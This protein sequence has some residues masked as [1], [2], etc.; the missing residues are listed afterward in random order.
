[1]GMAIWNPYLYPSVPVTTLSLCYP[2]PCP[3]LE[4]GR[5]QAE[6]GGREGTVEGNKRKLEGEER[7]TRAA[8]E[9]DAGGPC[10]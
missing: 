7:E 10:I 4:V 3:T 9:E 5:G 1:M 2:Y 8:V 6:R